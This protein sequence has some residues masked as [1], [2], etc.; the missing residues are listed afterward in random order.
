MII[1]VAYR[2]SMVSSKG[3]GRSGAIKE[4]PSFSYTRYFWLM[5]R[6]AM[7]ATTFTN[8]RQ[9]KKVIRLTTI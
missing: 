9:G 4:P 7:P 8:G 2:I 1:M 5:A 6:S 3:L